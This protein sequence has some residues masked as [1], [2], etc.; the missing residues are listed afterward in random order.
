VYGMTEVVLRFETKTDAYG[1]V[2]ESRRLA[3]TLLWD[4]RVERTGD[5]WVVHVPLDVYRGDMIADA[6][7]RF[8]GVVVSGP[9]VSGPA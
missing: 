2:S 5:G 1:Y 6:V 9:G 4:V 8:R 3:S 7:S